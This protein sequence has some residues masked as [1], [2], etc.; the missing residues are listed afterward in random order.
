[1]D[2]NGRPSDGVVTTGPFANSTG[3]WPLAFDGPSLRRR[4]GLGVS[5]LPTPADVAMA[6]AETDYDVAPWNLSSA[7]GF[8]NRLEGWI[9]G[10]QLHNRV[11]VWVGGSMEPM[12]SP[13]DPVFFLHHCFVDKVWADWQ[14]AFPGAPYPAAGP[15]VGHRLND[16]MSPFSTPGTP[17]RP[18]DTLDHHAMGYAYDNEDVCG[19]IKF[20]FLDD[21]FTLKFIDDPHG[22]LKFIDDGGLTKF[23][24]DPGKP[25]AVDLFDPRG[26]PAGPVVNPARPGNTSVAPFV[27]STP[28][29]S[30]AW[31][32]ASTQPQLQQLEQAIDELSTALVEA[33]QAD[34]R[35]GLSPAQ[36]AQMQNFERQLQMME[37]ERNRLKG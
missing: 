18:A 16:P 19:I 32:G 23:I 8:R 14:R 5:S 15:A 6:M 26:D 4:F 1:M 27:L 30:M 37:F 34:A 22:T 10:P 9:S 20:K 28:H 35:G 2:G 29:H 36:K 21:G 17:V 7:S 3:N 24:L 31:A 25:P 13:N 11:H 12:S 33:R